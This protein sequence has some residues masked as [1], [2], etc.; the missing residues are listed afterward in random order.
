[1]TFLH[2]GSSNVLHL[3]NDKY[4][5]HVVVHTIRCASRISIHNLHA[6]PVSNFIIKDLPSML[7]LIIADQV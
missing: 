4:C 1:M 6:S 3:T 5:K 2:K 7:I